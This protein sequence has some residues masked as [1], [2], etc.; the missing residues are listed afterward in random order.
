MQEFHRG[1]PVPFPDGLD[2]DVALRHVD[3]D[4]RVPV[5]CLVAYPG[6]QLR[7]AGVGGA[8]SE[9]DPDE[10]IGAV[11]VLVGYPQRGV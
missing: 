3:A 6:Q 8:W 7:R 5:P 11:I 2:L 9:A 10:A 4:D 1:P